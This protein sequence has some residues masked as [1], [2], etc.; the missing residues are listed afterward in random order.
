MGVPEYALPVLTFVRRSS[1][2]RTPDMGPVV[3][4]CRYDG[5]DWLPHG[6]HA[7][8]TACA[9]TR[10]LRQMPRVINTSMH[11]PRGVQVDMSLLCLRLKMAPMQK[12][13]SCISKTL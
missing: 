4:H 7:W 6:K 11:Q 10:Q 9:L 2:A 5:G 13:P 8:H 12:L 3:V 1:A